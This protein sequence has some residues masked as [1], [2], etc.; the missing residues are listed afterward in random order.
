MLKYS[1]FGEKEVR[2][3]VCPV[4]HSCGYCYNRTQDHSTF[5]TGPH[6]RIE[7]EHYTLESRCELED[8]NAASV[9]FI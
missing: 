1:E 4:C 8:D 9:I 3:T 7:K 6:H 2:V 5:S